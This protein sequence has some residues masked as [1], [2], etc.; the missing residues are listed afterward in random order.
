MRSGLEARTESLQNPDHGRNDHLNKTGS[1]PNDE[2][3]T[4]IDLLVP[5]DLTEAGAMKVRWIPTAHML[6]AQLTKITGITVISF[7]VSGP[8]PKHTCFI[9]LLLRACPAR[10]P[11]RTGLK[12]TTAKRSYPRKLAAGIPH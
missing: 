1:M 9:G 7:Y 6:A 8:A 12:S 3:Q 11:T 4:L 10:P 2:N 5:R